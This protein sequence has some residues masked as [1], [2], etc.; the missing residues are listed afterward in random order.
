MLSS[1]IWGGK[2]PKLPSG[3]T[4][5]IEDWNFSCHTTYQLESIM[6]NHTVLKKEI[7][8]ILTYI[9]VYIY[10]QIC[11]IFFSYWS[12]CATQCVILNTC[13]MNEYKEKY[14]ELLMIFRAFQTYHLWSVS[15]GPKTHV[16]AYILIYV[17]L[18]AQWPL[19]SIQTMVI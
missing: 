19:F 15:W 14:G 2:V 6:K 5:Y 9:C 17:Y 10:I 8:W 1:E 18:E 16:Y 7:L 11:V 12:Q 13:S 3:C 4:S